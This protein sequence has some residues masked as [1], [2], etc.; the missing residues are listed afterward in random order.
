MK[1]CQMSQFAFLG[2]KLGHTRT[3]AVGPILNSTILKVIRSRGVSIPTL[4]LRDERAGRVAE[5]ED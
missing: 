2:K 3:A 1:V 5:E 4:P